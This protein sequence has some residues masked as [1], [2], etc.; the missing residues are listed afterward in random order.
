[1]KST[2]GTKI[3]YIIPRWREDNWR[4]A[5]KGQDDPI[6]EGEGRRE[7]ARLAGETCHG[8]RSRA[9]TITASITARLWSWEGRPAI[10]TTT[11]VFCVRTSVTQ[12]G[13]AQQAYVYQN[14]FK[15]VLSE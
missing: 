4:Y 13:C 1:M 5:R 10:A 14:I 12:I 11:T 9:R 2:P 3:D 6:E 15:S 7:E 8:V